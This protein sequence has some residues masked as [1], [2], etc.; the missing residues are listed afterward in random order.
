MGLVGE[1]FRWLAR[2]P[3]PEDFVKLIPRDHWVHTE[4]GWYP[5]TSYVARF[6]DME[7]NMALWRWH[8]RNPWTAR[9][10]Q[11]RQRRA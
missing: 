1:M 6:D 3:R 2:R 9:R 5:V 7:F 4:L 8:S 10:A 11:Q